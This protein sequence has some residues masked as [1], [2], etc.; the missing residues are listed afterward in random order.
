MFRHHVA[1]RQDIFQQSD[2]RFELAQ[3]RFVG[4]QLVRLYLSKAC[5]CM[6]STVFLGNSF[7]FSA[8]RGR[9]AWSRHGLPGW[10][11]RSVFPVHRYIRGCI[12]NKAYRPVLRSPGRGQ[13]VSAK[14][15]NISRQRLTISCLS[16]R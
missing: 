8:I 16:I 7:F 11:S 14:S 4:Q 12:G 13:A 6:I 5:F 10:G 1:E 3:D 2:I 9:S 15:P